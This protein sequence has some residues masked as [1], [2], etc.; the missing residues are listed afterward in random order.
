MSNQ[1]LSFIGRLDRRE[2]SLVMN[3]LQEKQFVNRL[4]GNRDPKLVRTLFGRK[5]VRDVYCPP[6]RGV[7][8]SAPVMSKN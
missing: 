5:R 8:G 2:E 4:I 1:A 6:T 7:D 3:Q